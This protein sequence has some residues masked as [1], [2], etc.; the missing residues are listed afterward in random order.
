[1]GVRLLNEIDLFHWKL[2]ASG[3]FWVKSLYADFMNDHTKYPSKYLWKLKVPLEIR[4]FI[5]LLNKQVLL[6]K[7][8][9]IRR[10]WVGCKK[11][12]FCDLE[13]SVEHLFIVFPFTKLI[14]QVVYFIFNMTLPINIKN[15]LGK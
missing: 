14:W 8:N 1:M 4:I 6:T 15:L 13:E 2:T 11:C 9:L 5:W 7:D 3:D 10:N 12:A